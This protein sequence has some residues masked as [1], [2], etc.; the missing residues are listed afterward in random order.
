MGTDSKGNI[1][2]SD[3]KIGESDYMNLNNGIWIKIRED[4][5][6]RDKNVCV[7]CGAAYPLTVHHSK[8][9][10][11]WGEEN[12]NDLETLCEECHN[13]VHGRMKGE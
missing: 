11:I 9:P 13:K 8:Y 3:A 2:Y 5:K 12:L 6:R 7:H 1:I 4:V 10:Q